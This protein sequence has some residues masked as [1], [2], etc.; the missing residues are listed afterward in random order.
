MKKNIKVKVLLGIIYFLC[1]IACNE[2]IDDPI[3]QNEAVV[4]NSG[5][6]NATNSNNYTI[7]DVSVNANLLTLKISGSGCSGDSWKAVLVDANQI[8]ESYPIQRNI[9]LALENKEACLA[10]FEKEFT[11][12]VSVLKENYTEIILNLDGWNAQIRIN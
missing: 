3:L 10:V 5:L 7:T 11:F 2:T 4:I 6:Y 9:K 8:L 12:D 1:C